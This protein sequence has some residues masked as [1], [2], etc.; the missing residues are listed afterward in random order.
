[1]S[2]SVEL[3][4][5]GT[6]AAT[7]GEDYFITDDIATS[8]L[9]APIGDATNQFKGSLRGNSKTITITNFVSPASTTH[10][11]LFAKTDRARIE[12]INIQHADT[13]YIS[14]SSSSMIYVGLLAAEANDSF[15]DRITISGPLK[16][17]VQNGIP[18]V[19]AGGLVG[20]TKGGT[21]ISRS[22]TQGALT[23]NQM[24][25]NGPYTG[26][27]FV[28]G[29]LVGTAENTTIDLSYAEGK[30][31]FEKISGK[32]YVHIGGLVGRLQNSGT[33]NSTIKNS[34][35]A[36]GV[37]VAHPAY[38]S[39]VFPNYSAIGGLVGSISSTG[40]GTTTVESCYAAGPIGNSGEVIYTGGLVGYA[41]GGT[42]KK[43]AA[44]Y[45]SLPGGTYV[46]RI[47]GNTTG[48]LDQNFA[49]DYPY[50]ITAHNS[51][52]GF[53]KTI[54]ELKTRSTYE[55]GLGWDF[56]VVWKMPAA[57]GY[58]ILQWQ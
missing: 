10:I 21:V 40:T 15:F 41:N 32:T 16:I 37:G 27:V 51:N 31:T 9:W 35:A 57:P 11:G 43:S 52:D 30:A 45:S 18:S 4:D 36:G 44:I 12:D 47:A 38:S 25:T 55:T 34:Y 26:Q 13:N 8:G 6:D 7:L 46:H 54:A 49:H 22:C 28:L 3:A 29:A 5:I 42:L 20:Y 14:L 56:T 50:A 33:S 17:Q 58:P 24:D 48:T 19:Y 2:S 53:P 1:V 23:A 39:N